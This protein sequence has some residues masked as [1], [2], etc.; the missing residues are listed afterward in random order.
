MAQHRAERVSRHVCVS[1]TGVSRRAVHARTTT[2]VERR[3][4]R[5]MQWP[6]S[7]RR[8]RDETRD[9][10]QLRASR[11]PHMRFPS[12]PPVPPPLRLSRSSSMPLVLPPRRRWRAGSVGLRQGRRSPPSLRFVYR[13]ATL[14][15][16]NRLCPSVTSA[17]AS[18]GMEA[19]W[20]GS[21]LTCGELPPPGPSE[22][23]R[24]SH[25]LTQRCACAQADRLAEFG[26]GD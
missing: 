17:G 7:L 25:W 14:C 4:S 15:A 18:S 12:L 26:D 11:T 9:V 22:L 6:S 5:A 21:S 23:V 24:R 16:H 3:A 20:P 13:L 8:G 2:G 1:V 19:Q 10:S